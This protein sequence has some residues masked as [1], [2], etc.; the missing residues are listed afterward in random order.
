MEWRIGAPPSATLLCSGHVYLSMNFQAP[1]FNSTKL[2]SPEDIASAAHELGHAVHMF[3][4]PGS[5]QEFDDLPLDLL[6]LPST[7][8]ETI[9]MHPGIIPHYARHYASGGP[10][11]DPLVRSCQPG[12]PYFVRFLQSAHVA[13]GLHGD[14]FDPHSATPSEL[15]DAAVALWQR[16]SPVAA[17]PAFSPL[18]E[19]AGMYLALGASHV[20]YL[21][22]HLRADA[23]LHAA[24]PKQGANR[25][26][27]SQDVAQRWLSPEFAGRVRAQLLDRAFP[28][29]RLATLLPPLAAAA[30][31][32]STDCRAAVAL[33]HPLPPPQFNT[34]AFFGRQRLQLQQQQGV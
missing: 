8:A 11:P 17:H 6:E 26:Q 25:A 20:A 22:C 24:G 3:C 19:D 31:S 23:I 18:G 10:P 12:T 30:G 7:L 5:I 29:Q 13:L 14:A 2:L 33:P 21:L 28:G 15:Q 27:R 32:P 1:S 16:Y 4:H 34:D 9:A